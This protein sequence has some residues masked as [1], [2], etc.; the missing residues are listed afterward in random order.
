MTSMANK[1]F[2]IRRETSDVHMNINRT[3]N[4][5]GRIAHQML[6]GT[7][8]GITSSYKGHDG[9]LKNTS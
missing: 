7:E 1:E 8:E 2:G 9:H 6:L 4:E 3:L 5:R